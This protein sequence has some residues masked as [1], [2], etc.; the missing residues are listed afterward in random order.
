MTT[1]D[2]IPFKVDGKVMAAIIT[3]VLVIAGLY[4]NLQNQVEQ[5]QNISRDNN[6]ILHEIRQERKEQERIND[7]R[8]G[9]IENQL[10]TQEIRITVLETILKK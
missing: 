6:D 3:G 5:A 4:W 9:T 1:I 2:K 10:Q 8:L 7:I